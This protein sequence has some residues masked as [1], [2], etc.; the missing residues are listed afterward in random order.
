MARGGVEPHGNAGWNANVRTPAIVVGP[1]S[2]VSPACGN[3]IIGPPTL[4][5][6]I[7]L[8]V[9]LSSDDRDDPAA[10]TSVT[11]V[12]NL[13]PTL[14]EEMMTAGSANTNGLAP[15][16]AVGAV[17]TREL[18]VGPPPLPQEA[19]TR[20]LDNNPIIFTLHLAERR[21]KRHSAISAAGN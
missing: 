2:C 7:S 6:S 10:I 12:L 13:G 14:Q 9:T 1:N 4:D 16:V 11:L 18:V 17:D 19:S 5:P 3:V 20:T 8:K 15:A 21:S